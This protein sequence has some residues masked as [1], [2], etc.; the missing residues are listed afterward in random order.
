MTLPLAAPTRWY[1]AHCD[2]AWEHHNGISIRSLDNP[3]WWV[4]IDLRGTPL[5][6]QLFTAVAEG[7]DSNGHP[8]A[9]RWIQCQVRNGTWHGTGD[10]T[11]LDEIL[12]RFLDWASPDRKS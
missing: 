9:K 1:T 6:Y 10:E 2:G 5:E 7:V 12:R 3:G 8:K 11:R 4:T